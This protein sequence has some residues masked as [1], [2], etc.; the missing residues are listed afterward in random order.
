MI[1]TSSQR[2]LWSNNYEFDFLIFAELSKSTVIT[3]GD[4]CEQ[5]TKQKPPHLQKYSL[6][7]QSVT[8]KTK[9]YTLLC[10]LTVGFLL[11]VQTSFTM[12]KSEQR[13]LG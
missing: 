5:K 6:S 11:L 8:L 13:A 10:L 1:F 12:R 9:Y 2:C 7:C 4:G 3:D